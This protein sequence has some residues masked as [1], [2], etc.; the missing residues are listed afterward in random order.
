MA[1]RKLKRKTKRIKL[2]GGHYKRF[3]LQT[4]GFLNRYNFT[5]AGMHTV[6][7]ATKGLNSLT[8]RL[9]KQTSDKVNRLAQRR[10]KQIIDEGGQQV[11]R[12]APKIIH[13]AQSKT[14]TKLHSGYSVH[15]EETNFHTQRKSQTKSSRDNVRTKNIVVAILLTRT[16][17]GF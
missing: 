10:V 8:S 1:G 11:K 4:G 9:I 7:Q 15:L 2:M 13:F 14:F 3:R 17:Q 16:E 5:Y 12:I 6:N